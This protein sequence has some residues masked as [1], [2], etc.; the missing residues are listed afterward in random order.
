MNIYVC[1]NPL[2][3]EDSLPLRI[4]PLLQ[5]KRPLIRF[6]EFDPTEE[7]PREP[8]L[9]FIDTVINAKNVVLLKDINQFAQ[10]KALSLHDFDLGLNLKLAKKMGWLKKVKIIGVPPQMDEGKVVER[11]A[12]LLKYRPQFL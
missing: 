11:I 8:E 5:K 6:I 4:L 3:K 10:T 9:V 2:L 1:G 12:A 7:L